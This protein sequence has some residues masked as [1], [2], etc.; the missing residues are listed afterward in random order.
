MDCG[1]Q[2]R[3]DLIA[4]QLHRHPHRV[5]AVAVVLVLAAV[6]AGAGVLILAPKVRDFR[7]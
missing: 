3:A 5:A 4:E 2:G 7:G 6:A 1:C